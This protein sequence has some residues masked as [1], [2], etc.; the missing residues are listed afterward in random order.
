MLNPIHT[1]YSAIQQDLLSLQSNILHLNEMDDMIFVQNIL[2]RIVDHL[3]MLMLMAII[4]M[5][6]MMLFLEQSPYW[7]R[8]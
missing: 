3:L 8:F 4:L 2:Y 6:F 7:P 1:M 5:M